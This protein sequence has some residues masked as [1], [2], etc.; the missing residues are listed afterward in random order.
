MG[1]LGLLSSRRR[2]RKRLER[3]AG[4]DVFLGVGKE[5]LE[6]SIE[7]GGN[8]GYI[9]VISSFGAFLSKIV[10]SGMHFF[11]EVRLCSSRG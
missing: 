10:R 11:L 5:E 7:G 3:K 1:A 2:K 4:P 9:S 6:G 8:L